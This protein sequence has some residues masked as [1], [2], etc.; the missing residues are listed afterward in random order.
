MKK[1]WLVP[2]LLAL[3]CLS[4]GCGSRKDGRV[5]QS[6]EH[7][8]TVEDYSAFI[9]ETPLTE[10]EMKAPGTETE[11]VVLQTEIETES[12]Q[13]PETESETERQMYSAGYD[14]SDGA[15]KD[16]LLLAASSE[17][18]DFEDRT[19]I[20]DSDKTRTRTIRKGVLS[21]V[22]HSTVPGRESGSVE[23]VSTDQN[24]LMEMVKA[25]GIAQDESGYS[26]LFNGIYDGENA[27]YIGLK[28]IARWQE[29]DGIHLRLTRPEEKAKTMEWEEAGT[30]LEEVLPDSILI[31]EL[32]TEGGLREIIQ[33]VEYSEVIQK[34][35]S[36][37]SPVIERDQSGE[38]ITSGGSFHAVYAA[39]DRNYEIT[40]DTDTEGKTGFMIVL[41]SEKEITDEE[42]LAEFEHIYQSFYN[43]VFTEGFDSNEVCVAEHAQ[44]KKHSQ[45]SFSM[46]MF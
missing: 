7:T 15:V 39:D 37:G 31:Q 25:L 38:V 9:E 26:N 41:S 18:D 2:A 3:V 20:N 5:L 21:A 34:E 27:G 46:K 13:I 4:A 24:L 36:L 43:G 29:E 8:R 35:F 14:F 28:D 10:T 11:S 30:S 19:E 6:P 33:G 45:N 23:I 40:T 12:E 44:I 22:L 1:I 16:A 32:R 17:G 42:V